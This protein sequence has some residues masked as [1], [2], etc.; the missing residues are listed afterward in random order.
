MV[1]FYSFLTH[2]QVARLLAPCVFPDQM[3]EAS[4]PFISREGPWYEL[5][6]S[7]DHKV[8]HRVGQADT[9]GREMYCFRDRYRNPEREQR[10]REVLKIVGARVVP[11]GA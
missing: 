1:E 11:A 6:V 4:V 3:L 10:V 2:E 5:S 9:E 8:D 7:N